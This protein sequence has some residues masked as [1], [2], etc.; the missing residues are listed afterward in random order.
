MSRRGYGTGQ[1]YEKH[2]SWYGRW[3]DEDGQ[4]F[5]RRVGPVR[6]PKTEIG[7]TRKEAEKHFWKIRQA[8][9]DNPTNPA[10]GRHTVDEACEAHRRKLAYVGVS[11]SYMRG[12]ERKQRLHIGPVLGNRAL[13]RVTRRDVER[14]GESLIAKGLS[15]KTVRNILNYF[16]AVYEHAIDLEWTM[17]NP[18]RRAA[19]PRT[20]PGDT[21]P[22][23]QFLTV[24][25]LEAVIRTIPDEVVI[26]EPKSWR[27]GRAGVSPPPPADVTGPVHRILIRTAGMTGLR[28]SELIG[29]RWRDVDWTAQRIRVRRAIV[30][31]EGVGTGKSDLS[32]KRSVPMAD[33]LVRELDAWSKRSIFTH[34][35]DLVFAHPTI[36]VPLDGVKVTR[37][38][39]QGCR[40]AGVRVIRFHDLRHTFA[41]RLAASGQPMRSI[42]EFLGH[43]DSK[44]T[45]VYAHYAPSAHEVAMVNAAFAMETPA[46]ALAGLGPPRADPRGA[47]QPER[48]HTVPEMPPEQ[49]PVD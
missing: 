45:Q 12:C 6:D 38:F 41:T 34:Q 17:K 26:R 33:Q 3:R 25:E 30:R 4:R 10:A 7:L 2:G 35:D 44:T 27:T 43:S 48:S 24:E 16:N 1:V 37:R 39:Q 23:I 28:R 29:L 5:N 49:P 8:E 36:G 40:D 32:T 19:R 42:Q 11:K 20:R 9:E 13:Q 15:P 14:L 21:N 18:V 31:G 46:D 47:S 22:D